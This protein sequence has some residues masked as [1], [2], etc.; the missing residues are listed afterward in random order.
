MMPLIP[1]PVITAAASSTEVHIPHTDTHNTIIQ[2]WEMYNDDLQQ[3]EK[4][5]L[6]NCTFHVLSSG[7]MMPEPEEDNIGG[8]SV[9]G[10]ERGKGPVYYT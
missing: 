8:G 3:E 1:D 4:R 9:R 10:P 2:H 7:R 6:R 5:I